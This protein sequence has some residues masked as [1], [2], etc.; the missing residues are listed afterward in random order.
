[1]DGADAEALQRLAM[2]R[3]G[4]VAFVLRE[5]IARVGGIERDHQA[6]ARYFGE[7]GGGGDGGGAR[8]ALDEVA[9]RHGRVRQRQAVNE[10]D[11]GTGG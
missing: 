6:V 9:L 2:L 11:I 4:R 8:I 5:A 10:R 3:G 1:M 7:D